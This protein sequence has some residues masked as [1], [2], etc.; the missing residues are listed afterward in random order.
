MLFYTFNSKRRGAFLRAFAGIALMALLV[1][2]VNWSSIESVSA[3]DSQ[4]GQML[5]ETQCVL[6]HN[7]LLHLRNP[8]KAR[9]YEDVRDQVARWSRVAGTEWTYE[10]IDDVTDYLNAFFYR[11]PCPEG[12]CSFTPPH[13]PDR[14]RQ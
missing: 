6:C 7:S 11:Y 10:E 2:L 8:S 14:A 5:Y 1:G 4:R 9:S 3:A 12:Q 13:L